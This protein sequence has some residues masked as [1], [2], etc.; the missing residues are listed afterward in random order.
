MK[1]TTGSW[2]FRFPKQVPTIAAL[3]LLSFTSESAAQQPAWRGPIIPAPRDYHTMAYDIARGVTVM[4]GGNVLTGSY[5]GDSG[6][7]WEW[8]GNAWT[9]RLVAGPARRYG[10]AMA[11]DS[12]RGVTV[13]FGGQAPMLLSRETWEWDGNT[14]ILRSL[15]GPSA[16]EEHAMAYDVARGVTVLFGGDAAG[17]D[18]NGETWEWDGNAWTQRMVNGPSPR[19]WHAMAYD[20]ARGVTVL[21]GGH[22]NNLDG[23]TWEWNGTTWTLRAT[24]GP[25]PRQYHAMAY[26]TTR[27]MTVLSGGI[28]SSG[29]NGETWE[30]SG[31]SWTQRLIPPEARPSPRYQHDMAFDS[32]RG[33]TVLFG[34]QNGSVVGRVG[35][36]WEWDGVN[37]TQRSNTG[38]A[39]SIHAATFDSI[40]KVGVMV[41]SGTWEWDGL[42]WKLRSTAGPSFRSNHALAYDAARGVTVLCGGMTASVMKNDTWEWDGTTWTLRSSVGPS[43]RE[44]HGMAYDASRGVTV[45]FGGRI[46]EDYNF[47]RE[48]WEWD[49]S[50]WTFRTPGLAPTAGYGH[51]M[52]YDSTRSVTVC[53]GGYIDDATQSLSAQTC[54]WNGINWRV[55]SG[56]GPSA[57]YNHAMAFDSLRDVTLLFG[58]QSNDIFNIDDTWEWNGT[59]WVQRFT[60]GP[61]A[62]T[63]HAMFYDS[64]RAGVVLFGGEGNGDFPDTWEYG[65]RCMPCGDLD[66]DSDVD[67][68]DFSRFL[69][70]FGHAYGEA[71]FVVCADTDRNRTITLVDYQN[72]LACYRDFIGDPG[73]SAPQPSDLGDMNANGLLDARDIQPFIETLLA[74]SAAGLRA[75]L[76]ADVS[77]DGHLDTADIEPLAALLLQ[78]E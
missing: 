56:S 14:W 34:G 48:T 28:T 43:P 58:G 31:S 62:R 69:L 78:A 35:D 26:D 30:W 46:D 40:R 54:E 18:G 29:T 41:G 68:V 17:D 75:Q 13:V 10:H 38:S 12:A 61:P 63:N 32:A 77:A 23:D 47:S 64:P 22:S 36:T 73:A 11:Y 53:F 66:G 59:N 70:G 57:R 1:Q 52:T 50:S 21:F 5:A 2:S 3:T 42:T 24:T 49:G 16:R 15:T 76:V 25:S 71:G 7:T 55:R 67:D 6:Q 20:M 45:L 19:R 4:F 72:W 37:W 44:G 51:T 39:S 8:N 9:Q 33:V 60:T 27:N 74:P 65:F